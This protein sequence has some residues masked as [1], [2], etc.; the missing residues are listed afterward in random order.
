MLETIGS[1][2]VVLLAVVGAA[3]ICR[4]LAQLVLRTKGDNNAM[5]IVPISGHNEEAEL[6]LRSAAARIQWQ[7]GRQL[8]QVICLDCGMDEE[9][10]EVCTRISEDYPFMEVCS[11][12]E[13]QA[14]LELAK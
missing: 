8:Q 4:T 14:R 6:L 9:T 1:I 11:V 5:M 7:Q 2:L 13:L 12:Q 10:R 3:Q